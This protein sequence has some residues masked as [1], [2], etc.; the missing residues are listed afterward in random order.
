MGELR[1]PGKLQHAPPMMDRPGGLSYK[2][3][4]HASVGMGP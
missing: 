3:K 4:P 1:S 2:K